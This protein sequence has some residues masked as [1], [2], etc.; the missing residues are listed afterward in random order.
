M[1]TG[2]P[3]LP[4]YNAANSVSGTFTILPQGSNFAIANHQLPATAECAVWQHVLVERFVI[5]RP[6]G[7]LRG[8]RAMHNERRHYRSGLVH[9]H[10]VGA[11]KQ[12]I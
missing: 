10:G 4:Y 5:R 12:H 3:A 1:Q 7:Q 6:A 8:I 11:G 2:N 9:D